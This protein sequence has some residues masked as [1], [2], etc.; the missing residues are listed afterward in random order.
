MKKSVLVS[1]LNWG[2]GHATRISPVIQAFL[3][4]G[5]EVI[6]AAEGKAYRY[7]EKEFPDLKL[8]EIPGINV[9]YSRT[10][11][12]ALKLILQFPIIAKGVYKEHK[13]LQDLIKKHPIDL[14]VSDNRYGFYH[15]TI[16]SIFISHQIH[17]QMPILFRLIQ[18][19]TTLIIRGFIKRHNELWIP[20]FPDK[21][22]SLSG[23]LSHPAILK[24]A[25]YIGPLTRLKKKDI[26]IK[27]DF[28]ILL[29]GPEP[30][31]SILEE[32]VLQ[33]VILSQYKTAIVRGLPEKESNPL[34]AHQTP[35]YNHLSAE[36]LS[37][38]ISA[39][40][41]VI[42]RSGYSTVMDLYALNKPAVYIPTPG[43]TE[44]EHLGKQLRSE[45]YAMIKQ[46]HFTLEKAIKAGKNLIPPKR[47]IRENT[48]RIEVKRIIT[49]Y[50]NNNMKKS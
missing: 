4:E 28:L 23:K 22:T 47:N 46:K 18:P 50:I 15:K 17:V 41:F 6:L 29:S 1:P 33:N 38:I 25:T 12:L 45:S 37:E 30:Q 13:L 10:I 31:R 49:E 7:F 9:N 3:D 32:K 24:K 14:I 42:C 44:Q 40:K 39:S 43:Q 11:P 34:S 20:D 16:P 48:Y 26:P 8:F 2:L 21:K 35:M 5:C 27:Y 19:I 36:E